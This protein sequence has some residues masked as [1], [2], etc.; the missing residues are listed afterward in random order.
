MQP[1]YYDV[2]NANVLALG[3]ATDKRFRI[4]INRTSIPFIKR[5]FGKIG[6]E[7]MPQLFFAKIKPG[8]DNQ[9]SHF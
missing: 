3:S 5:S 4:S 7:G 6:Q 9:L 1:N 2:W 8:T